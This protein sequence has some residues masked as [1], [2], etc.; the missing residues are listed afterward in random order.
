[1]IVAVY[2]VALANGADGL[3]VA[4]VPESVTVPVTE[5]VPALSVNVV[6]LTDLTASLNVAVTSALTATPVWLPAGFVELT[7]GRIVSVGGG[8][9]GVVAGLLA[10]SP[11]K[12]LAVI[13]AMLVNPSPS[14]SRDSTLVILVIIATAEP[15]DRMA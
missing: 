3:K 11:G 8:G 15:N 2:V 5:A 10:G 6:A 9:G 1:V 12:V 4:V 13:S 7:V 14:E